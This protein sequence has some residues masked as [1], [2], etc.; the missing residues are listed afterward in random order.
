MRICLIYDCLYPHTVG[1]AERWYRNLAERLAADGHDV[2]YLTRRQWPRGTDPGVPGVK[3]IAVAPD[4]PLY[5]K[6]GRRSVVEPLVFGLGTFW[7]LLRKGRRYDVVHTAS[8]PY[9]HLLMAAL[10]RP[11]GRYRLVVDWHEVWTREYWEEYIGRVGGTIGYAVQRLCLLLPQSPFCFS[12]LHG[13]RLREFGVKGEPTVLEGEYAGSLEPHRPREA[14]PVVVF[15][16]RHI[17]EKRAPALVPAF[18]RARETLPDLR[19]ELFGDGPERPEVLRRVRELGANG[20]VDV[21]GFVSYERIEEA[22]RSALCMVLPSRREGYGLIVVEASAQ[23]TPSVVVAD[24]DNAATELVEEGVNGFIAESASPED[25]A[26]AI[27][28]VHEAG[29]A[30]RESTADWF[31]RNAERLSLAHSIDVVSDAYRDSAR[32]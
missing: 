13:S 8:F 7:H 26:A 20:A 1:G 16:G 4:L 32:S 21:P 12:R 22:L 15:A 9:F 29:A 25:L 2:T 28:R 6:S 5:V 17:P 10:L 19:L 31:A 30:L 27:L 24:P 11:L 3:V 18:A 14:E 23:G